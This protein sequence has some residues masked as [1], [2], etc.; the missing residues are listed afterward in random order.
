MFGDNVAWVRNNSV[1]IVRRTHPDVP[2]EKPGETLVYLNGEFKPYPSIYTALRMCGHVHRS[3]RKTSVDVQELMQHG[4][5]FELY[6]EYLLDPAACGEAHVEDMIQRMKFSS[7]SLRSR[8]NAALV[9][10][11]QDFARA[12]FPK[13]SLGREN[14]GA[15]IFALRASRA[16]FKHRLEQINAMAP[17]LDWREQ[18]VHS[19]IVRELRLFEML[20]KALGGKSGNDRHAILADALR[21]T[22][23]LEA[24]VERAKNFAENMHWAL[25]KNAI[26]FPFR[27]NA[28]RTASDLHRLSE[29]LEI[30]RQHR[31]VPNFTECYRCMRQIWQGIKWVFFLHALEMQ[32]CTPFSRVFHDF[33]SQRRVVRKAVNG[34]RSEDLD[35]HFDTSSDPKRLG[36]IL[37]R[38]EDLIIAGEKIP[39][40]LLARSPKID[41]L[42]HLKEAYRYAAENDDWSMALEEWEL[43]ASFI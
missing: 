6:A 14:V 28:Q 3:H 18:A 22:R 17:Y 25:L 15:R 16:Q 4:S 31:G 10:A 30:Y 26:A 23:M 43:A 12:L 13:D 9:A 7:A 40:T 41:V 32:I 39:V 33:E 8:R 2:A 34:A 42:E 20:R 19:E 37:Q 1:C 11:N 5:N 27:R 36:S 21:E 29:L 35:M 24:Q 38:L